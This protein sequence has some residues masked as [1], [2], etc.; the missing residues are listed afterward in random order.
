MRNWN[1]CTGGKDW[2]QCKLR[3]YLWGIETLQRKASIYGE[4]K[5]RAYLWGIETKV[6]IKAPEVFVWSCEPTY[7]ELKLEGT[8]LEK[9]LQ[10]IVAS[11][12][13]RNWNYLQANKNKKQ[14][15]CEPTY[16]ELKR[17]NWTTY[18]IF[19]SKLRAYLWGIE[20]DIK[21]PLMSIVHSLRAYL[22][23]IE[24]SS[25]SKIKLPY[26]LLRAY[27][28]GIETRKSSIEARRLSRLRAYLW[29]IETKKKKRIEIT[30]FT[31]ASLPMRNWNIRRR[32][33]QGF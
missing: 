16:E 32:N 6:A 30:I 9:P 13:M 3:A 20:T 18:W 10:Y 28:W 29:G 1:S 24:T 8:S 33:Q 7:E 12:P 25:F 31:I 22:W 2:F 23:G 11:L 27:L 5:L 17:K 26:S 15:G 14:L 21:L 4:T 19:C